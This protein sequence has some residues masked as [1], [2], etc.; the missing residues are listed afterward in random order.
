MEVESLHQG[1]DLDLLGEIVVKTQ[2]MIFTWC[3]GPECV[4]CCWAEV[5]KQGTTA[6]TGSEGKPFPDVGGLEARD[7]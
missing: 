2:K 3:S 4:H 7:L 1:W 5:V 6:W